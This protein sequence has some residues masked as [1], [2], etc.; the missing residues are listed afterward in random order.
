MNLV[1]AIFEKID[2]DNSNTICEFE[3]IAS[4]RNGVWNATSVD[5]INFDE[6][7]KPD[8][9]QAL[10]TKRNLDVERPVDKN[11]QK[12]ESASLASNQV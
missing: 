4:I 11:Y 12:S 9:Y 8:K 6:L 7:K 5:D 1:N 3:F 10:K 2:L